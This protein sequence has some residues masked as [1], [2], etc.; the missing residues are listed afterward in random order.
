MP[1]SVPPPANRMAIA[2]LALIGFFVS[3][4]LLTHNLGILGPLPCGVGDCQTVQSSVYARVGPLP[5][6]AIGSLGY[7][8]LLLVALLGLQPRF[9]RSRAVSHPLFFGSMIGVAYSAYLTYLEAFVI[10]AWCQWCVV[11]AL[12]ITLVFLAS[13]P[14]LRR[15]RSRTDS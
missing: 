2:I 14:E 11:S 3:I 10:K 8:L 9:R 15:E 13:L 12:L 4:F 1:S 5:V 7:A 6:S